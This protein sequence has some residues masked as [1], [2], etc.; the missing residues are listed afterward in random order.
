[1]R[2]EPYDPTDANPDPITGQPGAHPIGTGVGAAGAGVIGTAV[3]GA[4]G[5]PV[6]AVVGA[7]IGAVAGGLAGKGAAEQINPTMEADYWRDNYT[8]R[9]YVKSG[10]RYEDYEPAYRTG[11]EGYSRYASSGRTYD[12]VEPDLRR[13]YEQQY[14]GNKLGW[15]QAKYATKDAWDRL[16]NALPG[17]RDRPGDSDYLEH[18]DRQQDL[19]NQRLDLYEERLVADKHRDKVGEVT[20]GKHVETEKT[21]VAMPIE[22]ERVVVERVEPIDAGTP[23]SADVV[24]F[25]EAEVAR[26]DVYEEVPDIHKQTIV[27]EEVNVKKVVDQ[28]VVSADEKLRRETLDVDASNPTITNQPTDRTRRDRF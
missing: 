22:K 14:G 23:V 17:D 11:Y 16:A 8:S 9:P 21:H 24:D 3:G 20:V 12:Q 5:G 1:M 19:T 26:M 7:A 28:E 27:R 25:G 6:G 10:Q 4:I 18:S 15:E 13:D 2:K